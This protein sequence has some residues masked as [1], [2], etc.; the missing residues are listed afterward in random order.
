MKSFSSVTGDSWLQGRR[1]LP[2]L[3]RHAE[4]VT[5]TVLDVGCG[6]S[7]FRTLFTSAQ[8]YVRVDCYPVD[9]EVIV[10]S[11]VKALPFD[12]GSVD[13]ILLAR[14]MGDLPDV[15]AVLLELERVL[16]DTGVIVVYES[17]TYP[18][19]DLPNDYWRVLPGGLRWAA[20]RVG[21]KMLSLDYL[22]GYFTQWAMHWNIFVMG[23]L[24]RFQL[25][26]PFGLA[27]RAAGNL[28]AAGLDKL[29]PRPTL[30]SDY[31]ACLVKCGEADASRGQP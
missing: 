1:L 13:F 11:D 18:Q 20:S 5:G 10:V 6:K 14:M 3:K 29:M 24:F 16:K 2:L 15:V 28:A 30:A 9:S 23:P 25:S 4:S 8:R 19:H 22:G 12:T 26:R 31:L 27:G 17:M 7:P 21:L